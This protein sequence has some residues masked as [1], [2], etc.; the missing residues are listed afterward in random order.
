MVYPEAMEDTPSSN[1]SAG[2]EI[3]A[4]LKPIAPLWQ[5]VVGIMFFIFGFAVFP[6]TFDL[7]SI[8][9]FIFLLA[10]IATALALL[11]RKKAMPV[12]II[13]GEDCILIT[14]PTR[15]T[16]GKLIPSKVIHEDEHT[17]LVHRADGRLELSRMEFRFA[18][19]KDTSKAMFLF[20]R[21]LLKP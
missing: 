9:L 16:K 21:F 12:T 17:I 20:N 3:R 4:E 6:Q 19:A 11:S 13:S 1:V 5:R 7:I 18:N 8:A 15:P 10:G 2:I 14:D